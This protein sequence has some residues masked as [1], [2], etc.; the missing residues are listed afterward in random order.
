MKRKTK[1][2][3]KLSTV[4]REE[5]FSGKR[6]KRIR[7]SPR[8][9]IISTPA[10]KLFNGNTSSKITQLEDLTNLTD[11]DQRIKELE[12]KVTNL[13]PCLKINLKKM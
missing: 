3:K 2:K 13:E 8:E 1:L 9:R 5:S 10:R 7:K 6:S 12:D 4:E 11:K